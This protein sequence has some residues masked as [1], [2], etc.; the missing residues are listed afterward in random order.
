MNISPRSGKSE[1][2]GVLLASRGEVTLNIDWQHPENSLR[3]A[4][5]HGTV[6]F[7]AVLELED[8]ERS[9]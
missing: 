5:V 8:A 4:V 3:T 6:N 9:Q 7:G 2:K 1:G